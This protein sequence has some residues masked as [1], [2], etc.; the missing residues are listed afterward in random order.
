MPRRPKAYVFDSW[1]IVAFLQAEPGG[2]KVTDLVADAHEHRIPLLMS[3]VNAGEVWYIKARRSSPADA[4]RA[5]QE[6]RQLGIHF[7]EVDWM[8]AHEAGG[9]KAKNRMSFADCFAAALAKHRKAC[10]VTGDPEFKQ[11]EQEITITWLSR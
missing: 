6:L 11:I 10:L 1:A 8:L 5:I 4:D 3:V 2:A 9:F 7:V